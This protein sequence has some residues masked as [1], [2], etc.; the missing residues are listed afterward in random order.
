M[1][2][3]DQDHPAR[4]R[5]TPELVP[6]DFSSRSRASSFIDQPEVTKTRSDIIL[7]DGNS[8]L[9]SELVEEISTAEKYLR[10]GLPIRNKYLFCGPPGCGKTLCAEVVAN[11]MGLDLLVVRLDGLISSYLGETATN[12]RTVIEAAEQRPCV[13]FFDEFDALA[14]ARTESEGHGEL[15]RVVNSLLVLIQNFQGRGVLIAAT[16]LENTIDDA[17]WRRFDEVLLFDRPT[18]KLTEN[19]LRLKTR[20]FKPSFSISKYGSKLKGFSYAQIDGLCVQAMKYAISEN[21]KTISVKHFERAL[22]DELRRQ[23]VRRRLAKP[24][25]PK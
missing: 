9:L 22:K 18:I 2:K 1:L 17:L 5:K 6:L 7:S 4:G 10:H 12:L 21:R 24:N 13:L 14:R 20:N 25:K 16:N 8:A 3:K 19:F 15:R 23:G 11:E